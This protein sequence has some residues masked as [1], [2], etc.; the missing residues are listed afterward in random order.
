[1]L[2]L[3]KPVFQ[4][5]TTFALAKNAVVLSNSA[6]NEIYLQIQA[7]QTQLSQAET[8]AA[9]SELVNAGYAINTPVVA[10]GFSVAIE[11]GTQAKLLIQNIPTAN[12]SETVVYLLWQVP[13]L[14]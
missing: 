1:M 11:K 2:T 9:V 4:Q 7:P 6:A 10:A 5:T 13:V 14:V 3:T 12:G 8:M